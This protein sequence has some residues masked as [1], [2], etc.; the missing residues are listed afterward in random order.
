M[1]LLYFYFHLHYTVFDFKFEMQC[2]YYVVACV[3]DFQSL[4]VGLS[5]Y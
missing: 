2:L 4:I 3:P 5:I 1:M